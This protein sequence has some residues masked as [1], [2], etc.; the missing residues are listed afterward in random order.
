MPI[1]AMPRQ[2][3]VRE[4][5]RRGFGSLNFASKTLRAAARSAACGWSD[6]TASGAGSAW[7]GAISSVRIS[8]GWRISG[9]SA[10]VST[11]FSGIGDGFSIRSSGPAS[12]FARRWA[13]SLAFSAFFSASR[14][15]LMSRGLA[16][17]ERRRG[18]R[19]VGA[20]EEV[21]PRQLVAVVP[22]VA[23]EARIPGH[24]GAEGDG[25]LGL[26]R[27]VGAVGHQLADERD[28]AHAGDARLLVLYEVL[29][30]AG[31][32]RDFA[33]LQDFVQN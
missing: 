29:H 16:R 22:E 6:S 19:R 23:L 15:R 17:H 10:R 21:L 4:K 24:G 30:Q 13:S 12:P 1:A 18:A 2:A 31:E 27:Q 26:G 25:G 11:G 8:S 32:H 14:S 5:G 7:R 28:A 33:V 3:S 9:S 20:P